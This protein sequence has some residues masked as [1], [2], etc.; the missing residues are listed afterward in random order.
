MSPSGKCN[1]TLGNTHGHLPCPCIYM[2]NPPI[3][4]D[5]INILTSHMIFRMAI[6]FK[7]QIHVIPLLMHGAFIIARSQSYPRACNNL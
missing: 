2:F 4:Y 5:N 1:M 7:K 3:S 6:W